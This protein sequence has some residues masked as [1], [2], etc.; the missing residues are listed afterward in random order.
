MEIH[1]FENVVNK[2]K[3]DSLLIIDISNKTYPIQS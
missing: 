3:I 1:M 2:T